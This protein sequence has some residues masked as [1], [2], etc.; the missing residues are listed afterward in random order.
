MLLTMSAL[1]FTKSIHL[2]VVEVNG[3]GGRRNS[4]SEF[5]LPSL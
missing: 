2:V 4:N 3:R 1:N 5:L